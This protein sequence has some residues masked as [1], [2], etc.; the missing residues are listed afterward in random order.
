MFTFIKQMDLVAQKTQMTYDTN[1]IKTYL[2]QL[3]NLKSI[4]ANPFS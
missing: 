2:Y 1:S 4:Q 3:Y